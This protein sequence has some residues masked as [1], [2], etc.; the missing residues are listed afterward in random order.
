MHAHGH[1]SS[2]YMKLLSSIHEAGGVPC[3]AYP[4]LW[5]PEDIPHP[6]TR[7]N[8]TMIAKDFCNVCPIKQQCFEYALESNQMYGIWGGT[9]PDE[10]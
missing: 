10:R 3:E 9:S 7:R 6:I 1:F 5:F 4:D 2:E 8:A